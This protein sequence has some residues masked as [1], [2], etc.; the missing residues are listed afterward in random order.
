[1]QSLEYLHMAVMACY[2]LGTILFFFGVFA[3]R[4]PLRRL[5]GLAALAGFGLHSVDL[6]AM[7]AISDAALLGGKFHVSFLAWAMLAT[8]FFLWWKFRSR[9]LGLTALPLALLLFIS[10]LAAGGIRVTIPPRFTALF[11]GLHVGSLAVSLGLMALAL[12]AGITWLNLNKKL[13]S[14][15]ALRKLDGGLPSLAIFDSINHW[16]IAIGFPLYTLGVCSSFVWYWIDPEKTFSWD[17][18]KFNSLGVWLLFAFAFHQRVMLGWKGRKP[19]L[20]AICIFFFLV[21]SLAHHTIS[22]KP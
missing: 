15:E 11:F 19:A 18:M 5:A 1:M 20:L 21:I 4:E 14:K 8:W 22:F 6:G 17:A 16:A 9:Y 10:S 3:G 13:K 2:L 12:G 7:L